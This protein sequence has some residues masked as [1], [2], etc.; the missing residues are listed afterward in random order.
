MIFI[1][2]NL[3]IQNKASFD[4]L[5]NES[6]EKPSNGLLLEYCTSNKAA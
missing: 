3:R 1:L 5:Y 6:P 2:F 4:I